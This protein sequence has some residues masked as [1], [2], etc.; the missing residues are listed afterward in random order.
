MPEITASTFGQLLDANAKDKALRSFFSSDTVGLDAD[1]MKANY[2]ARVEYAYPNH[3]AFLPVNFLELAGIT[4][5]RQYL[6][7]VRWRNP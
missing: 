6:S 3:T 5:H 2:F 4:S 7:N 1:Q